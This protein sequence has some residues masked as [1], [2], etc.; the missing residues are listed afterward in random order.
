MSFG[1]NYVFSTGK[2]EMSGKKTMEMITSLRWLDEVDKDDIP[3]VG[4]KFSNLGEVLKME[5]NVPFG[6][7]VTTIAYKEFVQQ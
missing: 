3:L 2:W 1:D 4:G 7:C 5:I 6:F